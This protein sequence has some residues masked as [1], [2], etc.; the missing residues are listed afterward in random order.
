[1]GSRQRIGGFALRFNVALKR[2]LYVINRLPSAIFIF[3]TLY[4]VIVGKL[5]IKYFFD[6]NKYYCNKCNN[7]NFLHS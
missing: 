7:K 4:I 3:S 1:M 5:A 2:T 6:T